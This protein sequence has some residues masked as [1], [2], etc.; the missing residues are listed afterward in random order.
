MYANPRDIPEIFQGLPFVVT[1][2]TELLLEF[3]NSPNTQAVRLPLKFKYILTQ[4]PTCV[5]N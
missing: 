3:S 5:I 2:R 4:H 1:I